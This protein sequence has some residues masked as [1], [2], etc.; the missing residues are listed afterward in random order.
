MAGSTAFCLWCCFFAA[1]S[2]EEL[3]RFLTYKVLKTPFGILAFAAT[4][5]LCWGIPV[6]VLTWRVV[7]KL[8]AES[9]SMTMLVIRFV[10][11]NGAMFWLGNYAFTK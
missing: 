3:S 10:A 8:S 9:S 11:V 6:I 4:L 1:L 5:V 2:G 7:T